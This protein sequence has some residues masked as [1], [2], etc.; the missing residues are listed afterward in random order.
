[1][2]EIRSS[3]TVIA[4]TCEKLQCNRRWMVSGTPLFESI[5]DFR[6][7]LNFLRLHPFGALCEDGFF[8][9]MITQ[10]WE[11]K[12][13]DAIEILKNLSS[14]L[15]RRTKSMTVR[16]T[17][18]PLLGLPEMTVEYVPVQQTESERALYCYLEAIV[19]E[20]LRSKDQNERNKSRILCLRLLRD[21]C[22][23][24]VSLPSETYL[25][26]C[27]VKMVASCIGRL[28]RLTLSLR[29]FRYC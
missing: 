18:A 14:V 6:G 21:V 1:M 9:F 8:D 24:A 19:S 29:Y 7:E 12:C 27:M 17:G 25:M 22:N 26:A 15:L 5:D 11:E 20:E 10:P 16:S 13:T 23:S 2:Q 4:Q 28:K 3:T